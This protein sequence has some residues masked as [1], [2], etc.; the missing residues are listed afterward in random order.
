MIKVFLKISFRSS[1][2]D[3]MKWKEI[4]LKEQKKVLHRPWTPLPHHFLRRHH[5]PRE[6][7]DVSVSVYGRI[8]WFVDDVQC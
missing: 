5:R 6:S 2:G 3:Q 4:K 1:D 8:V 7:E